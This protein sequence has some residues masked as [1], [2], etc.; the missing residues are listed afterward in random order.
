MATGA[1][2]RQYRQAQK[3][4][5]ELAERELRQ[6]FASLNPENPLAAVKAL[7]LLLPEL[8][9]QYGE[10]GATVAADFYDELRAG[11]VAKKTF[12]AVLSD[13]IPV[14]QI[15][16]STKWAV[17]PLF[18]KDTDAE[19]ALSNLIDVTDRLVKQ[20]GRNTI[21]DNTLRDPSKARYARVPT[22]SETCTF[23]L[24]LASRGAEYK[25][26]EAAAKNKYHGKCDCQPVPVWDDNDL[27]TL[28][29]AGYDP[30]ALYDRWQD[31][32]AAEQAAKANN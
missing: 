16:V 4:V 9:R 27:S 28:H 14:E 21:H 20:Q 15:R 17:G 19:A 25:S 2:V 26:A 8:I 32:L 12:K 31:Q 5:V 22:G 1:Q 3:D 24:M 23:C 18:Q 7:E 6:F 11:S 10:I 30:D 29:K 13:P